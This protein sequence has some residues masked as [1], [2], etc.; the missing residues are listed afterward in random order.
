MIKRWLNLI[1]LALIVSGFGLA[2]LALAEEEGSAPDQTATLGSNSLALLGGPPGLLTVQDCES[3]RRTPEL[4][5]EEKKAQLNQSKTPETLTQN[6]LLSVFTYNN[7]RFRIFCDPLIFGSIA[8]GKKASTSVYKVAQN[9]VNLGVLIALL[10]IAF[11]NI[12]RIKLDTYAVKKSIPLL[13]FGVIMANLSLPIIRT[14]IDLAGVLTATFIN[15]SSVEGTIQGFVRSLVG[16][17]YLGGYQNLATA[18][19]T[20]DGGSAWAEILGL[21][22]LAGF[23]ILAFGPV[24]IAVSVGALFL[25]LLPAFFF[26]LLGLLFV[27]RIYFL[28][29]LTAVAPVA[30]ASLGFEPLRSRVWGWWWTHFLK[31]TFMAPMTFFLFWLGVQ[32]FNAADGVMDIGTYVMVMFLLWYATQIPLKWG[33]TVMGKWN[34]WLVKPVGRGIQSLGFRQAFETARTAPARAGVAASRIASKYGFN[35]AK[36]FR[37]FSRVREE[38]GAKQEGIA[39]STGLGR[40]YGGLVNSLGLRGA[41]RQTAGQATARFRG[42]VIDPYATPLG[43]Q[44]PMELA[45]DFIRRNVPKNWRGKS[46]AELPP[47]IQQQIENELQANLKNRD[48]DMVAAAVY[49]N[50]LLGK[51]LTAEEKTPYLEALKGRNIKP[52]T[53]FDTANILASRKTGI[54]SVNHEFLEGLTPNTAAFERTVEGMTK[55]LS[56]IMRRLDQPGNQRAQ[57]TFHANILHSLTRI[58]ENGQLANK[59]LEEIKKDPQLSA[60]A[61]SLIH[62]DKEL[63]EKLESLRGDLLG[64]KDALETFNIEQF[65]QRGMADTEWTTEKNKLTTD[66]QQIINL[67]LLGNSGRF[68]QEWHRLTNLNLQP[69]KS[70]YEQTKSNGGDY[71]Q[72]S[73]IRRGLRNYII[74]ELSEAGI[75]STDQPDIVNQLLP[76]QLPGALPNAYTGDNQNIANRLWRYN[77]IANSLQAMAA[78]ESVV[79]T[80]VEKMIEHDAGD[81]ET[82]S[83]KSADTGGRAAATG[84]GA[85][86]SVGPTPSSGAPSGSATAAGGTT[87]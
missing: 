66:P 32:F 53:V 19:S 78:H 42:Q 28:V 76:K 29:I 65:M 71:Q 21:V 60:M 33:T 30:F 55:Q 86:N 11:A 3:Q 45:Q 39:R 9:L 26:F 20:I 72:D 15:D 75:N 31:W 4:T 52:G 35:L 38:E 40:F 51:T 24:F 8:D 79:A 34:D 73:L 37:E 82:T 1:V 23:A 64:M 41:A 69:I 77:E 49:V 22:G 10:V 16:A 47:E 68:N 70:F 85:D 58:N 7:L 62:H 56:D 25:I 67:N 83:T 80:E 50:G 27:A 59:A 18:F 74:K 54:P 48:N 81:T 14:F 57:E 84:A 46:L 44:R 13:V 36:S 61:L 17:V 2:S 63:P 6:W 87:S 12:L 43:R 5:A